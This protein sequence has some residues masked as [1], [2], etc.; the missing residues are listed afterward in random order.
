MFIRIASM[1]F[2]VAF[3]CLLSGCATVAHQFK[4]GA[5]Y[6]KGLNLFRA[7]KYEEAREH[8]QAALDLSPE[9][10]DYLALL[11][12]TFLRQSRYEEAQNLFSRVREMD[13][14]GV[15]GP[16]GLAWVDYSLGKYDTSEKWFIQQLDWARDHMGRPEWI[17]YGIRDTL[18]VNSIR[19]DGAYGLGLVALARGKL[20]EAESFL[21]EALS[22]PNDFMGHGPVFTALGDVYSAVKE[23]K[24]AG[25]QYEKALALKE[26]GA[27]AAK[28]AWCEYRLG[29]KS[30]ADQSFL[31][32]LSSG[33]DR[34]PGLYGLVFTRHALGK[35]SEA[36]AYLKELVRLDPYFADTTDLYELIIRTEGWRLIWKDF[37]QTYFEKGDFA[38][39]A[40]KLEGYLPSS[41]QECTARLMN[42]WCAF[43]LRG[44]QAGLAEFSKLSGQRLCPDD[45]V[46]TGKGVALLY[47]NRLDEAAEEFNKAATANPEN[48]R[49]AVALGA[50]AFLKGNHQEA[51][52]IYS[53]N[54]H[55][56]PNEEIYFSWPSHALNNLGWSYIKTRKYPEA[57]HAF[58]KLQS[59][60]RKPVY[61]E[62][63]DGLGWSLFY[64][65][66]VQEAKKAF[67]QALRFAPGYGSS[68]SGLALVQKTQIKNR[69]V[70]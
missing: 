20:R 61:P 26:D 13:S 54:L 68:L 65:D 44:P 25:I 14:K 1:F 62:I 52:R 39:A 22:C 17:Y 4:A 32:I 70:D 15:S 47:S 10:S 6:Q 34:R 37:A 2:V 27:T 67:E 5:E 46:S 38:R 48:V 58:Q 3:A 50:V 64:L 49:S 69:L 19:S 40:F 23:Y 8:V 35:T 29:D 30:G 59:I 24:K 31:R 66:R 7:E 53:R 9:Q 11:G 12:W 56:L 43:Y 57:L 16:Q 18:Y 60:H 36:R 55:R 51:I 45:Q 41:M 28:R 63:F 33:S 21:K 42:G